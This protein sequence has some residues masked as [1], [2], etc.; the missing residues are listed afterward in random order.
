MF[1][2]GKCHVFLGC[3]ILPRAETEFFKVEETLYISVNYINLK[4]TDKGNNF[5]ELPF[6]IKSFIDFCGDF[7]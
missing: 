4:I 2:N 3:L 6:N 1:R 5:Q 7:R